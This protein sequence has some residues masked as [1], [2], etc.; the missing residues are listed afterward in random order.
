[1]K[2]KGK[3]LNVSFFVFLMMLN[4]GCTPESPSSLEP[5]ITIEIDPLPYQLNE[6]LSTDLDEDEIVLFKTDNGKSISFQSSNNR[7]IEINVEDSFISTYR[8]TIISSNT[9]SSG[10]ISYSYYKIIGMVS[11]I[12]VGKTY[13]HVKDSIY[14]EKIIPVTILPE[15]YTFNELE[16][17]F[18]DTQDSVMLKVSSLQYS[19]D[20]GVY[21]I[22]DPH[23]DYSL[24]VNYSASGTVDSYEVEL[25]N[26][27][28]SDELTGYVAERY[29]KT[30]AYDN[31]LP[32]YIKAYNI[33]SPSISDASI[34][35]ILNA[36]ARRI[37]YR[38][39]L[40]FSNN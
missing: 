38:N 23:N 28:S 21:Y 19:E 9:S 6:W 12:H 7:A 1:M 27:V 39:P 22:I 35:V 2:F 40:T 20:D 17:D 13:L 14:Y 25:E 5:T 4:S 34:I 36:E 30:N 18:D 15:Y 37:T 24:K 3:Y 16:L 31:G 26:S 8:P 29:Y 33:L 32:V 10:T 11:P